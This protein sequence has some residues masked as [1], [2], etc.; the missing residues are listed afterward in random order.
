VVVHFVVAI[1]S[2]YIKP[3]TGHFYVHAEV[4]KSVDPAV[5]FRQ[6]FLKF[7]RICLNS[8]QGKH[9]KGA[10]G[11]TPVVESFAFTTGRDDEFGK[12]DIKGTSPGAWHRGIS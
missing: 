3:K 4:V 10:S 6:D 11:G 1:F 5:G 8:L 2:R 7:L 12:E 9:A